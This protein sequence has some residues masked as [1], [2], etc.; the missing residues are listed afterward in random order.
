MY[1][2]IKENEYYRMLFQIAI[3]IIIQNI[4]SVSLN[5]VDTIMVGVLGAP[6]LVAISIVNQI[7]LIFI[8]LLSSLNIA[9]SVMITQ[10]WGKGDID[11]VRH[12]LGVSLAIAVS[13]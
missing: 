12:S 10:F 3:P 7:F 13:M 1:K 2:I 8:V 6:E 4:I 5:V 9:A 11:E